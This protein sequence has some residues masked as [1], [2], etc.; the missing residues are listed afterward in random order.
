MDIDRPWEGPDAEMDW[1][2]VDR[3]RGGGSRKYHSGEEETGA[4]GGG[5]EEET[6]A[7]GSGLR[8]E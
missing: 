5:V 6:D 8:Q 1:L 7:R 2:D 3:R 4:G